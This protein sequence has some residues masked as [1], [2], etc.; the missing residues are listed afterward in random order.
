M[1]TALLSLVAAASF[2]GGN[3]S[4]L[5]K[6]LAEA[7]G[8]P[9]V[10]EAGA[11]ESAKAFEFNPGDLNE[12]ARAVQNATDF[13][14]APGAEHAFHHGRLG[15]WRFASRE[16]GRLLR[17]DAW[18]VGGEWPRDAFRDGKVTLH[19]EAG[20]STSIEAVPRN[21]L[22]KPL[23]VHWIFE[24]AAFKAWVTDLPAA[25]FLQHL[26]KALGGR[27]IA[28]PEAMF[29]DVDAGEI[30]RRAVATF[31]AARASSGFAR[32][33]SDDRARLDL[34]RAAVGGL[35]TGQIAQLLARPDGRLRLEIGAGF[36]PSVQAYIQILL[37]SSNAS[38]S[39]ASTSY[40]YE[41]EPSFRISQRGRRGYSSGD[42]MRYLLDRLDPR[43][44]GYVTVDARFNVTIELVGL[45]RSGNSL[46]LHRLP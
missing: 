10:F 3:V 46:E 4:D 18:R 30:Q 43:I 20:K 39:E 37:A 2:P 17:D 33:D 12:L 36:R 45:N 41:L 35:S 42:R 9:V 8:Q 31:A 16:M 22:E 11:Q 23:Q 13:R 29:L 34:A 32:L 6:T 15:S 28:R 40:L 27:L 25:E 5:A 38:A 44:L 21:L 19:H 14:R 26:A 1:H 24:R 7:T